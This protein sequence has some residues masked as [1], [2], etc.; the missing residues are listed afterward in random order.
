MSDLPIS[1]TMTAS[2][3][4]HAL[5]EGRISAVELLDLHLAQI[6]RYNAALNAIVIGNYE[7]A[8]VEAA[9]ADQARAGGDDRPLLG[10]PITV[11]DWIEVGGLRST[12]GDSGFAAGNY[13]AKSDGRVIAR[14]RA[15]GAIVIGKTNMAPWG[16]EWFTDNAVFGRSNNPWQLEHTPGGSTGGGAAAVA[17]GLS[18]LEIGN[19][20]GGSVRIPPAFCG[21]YGHKPS[22]SAWPRTGQT[23]DGSALHL[24]NPVTALGM[25]GPLARSAADLALAFDTGCGPDQGEDVAWRLA[26]PPARHE[27]LQDVRVAV[28]PP[29][30]WLHVADDISA[31]QERLASELGRMGCRVREAMPEGFGDLRGFF[32]LNNRLLILQVTLGLGKEQ[33]H[34]MAQWG[35]KTAQERNDDIMEAG[36]QAF[37]ASAYDYVGWF[38][39][40]ERYRLA[41]RQ[42]FKD[43]DVLLTPVSFSPAFRHEDVAGNFMR[44]FLTLDIDGQAVP[45]RYLGVHAALATLCGQPATAFPFGLAQSGLPIG[46]QAIGP[47]LEDHTPLRFAALVG[48]AFGGYQPPPLIR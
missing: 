18:P 40:R 37:E 48:Q 10:L 33:R 25:M 9:Q 15:A 23:P 43:W 38:W 28:L 45:Y 29:V 21:V 30:G 16:G 13:V 44:D 1:T 19:D 36:A 39:R 42:F 34:E 47:Y 24:P 46:L 14:L 7:T 22:E 35:H 3:M 26:I 4:L 31:A 41:Y 11:K 2:A 17:A 12:A 5:R 32:K 8:R 6:E 27:R 20:I